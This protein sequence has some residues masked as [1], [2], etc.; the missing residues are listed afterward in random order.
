M[1][2]KEDIRPIYSELQGYLSQAPNGKIE[3]ITYTKGK[4]LWEQVNETIDE[5]SK[6]TGNDYSRFKNDSPN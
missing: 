2:E 6:I 4:G 1:A 3:L 5:L